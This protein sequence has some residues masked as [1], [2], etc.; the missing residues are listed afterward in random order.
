MGQ[1]LGFD[2]M[3]RRLYP[4]TPSRLRTWLDCPRRYRMTYLDRP[5]PPKGPPWAINSFGA[6]VHNALA[7]WWRLPRGER[8]VDAAGE[9]LERGWINEGYADDAQSARQR[10]RARA[11]VGAYVAKLDPAAEPAGVE[12]VVAT[13][14]DLIAVS[15]RIDRLDDRPS[16]VA[17]T[18]RLAPEVAQ[19]GVRGHDRDLVVV[20][21]KTGRV[22][23]ETAD[24]RSSLTLALYALA[25]GR[26]LRR[27]CAKVELHHLPTGQVAGWEHTRES[28]ERHL[29]RAEDIAA[30]CADADERFRSQEAAQRGDD[31]FPPRLGVWCGWCDF[32]AHCPPGR[33]AAP[34]R[35]PWDGLSEEDQP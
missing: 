12:R 2:G 7:G 17:V 19:P 6:S 14:T 15:G 9:L 31:V 30:E 33:L 32:R 25:A 4:C 34:A 18:D 3:P 35:R 21:Y 23:P 24:V 16:D 13:K 20:D 27:R 5:S 1:Q 10:R 11:M 28:L 8:S 29:R 22:P 26:V